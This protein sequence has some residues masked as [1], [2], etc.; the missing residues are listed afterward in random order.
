MVMAEVTIGAPSSRVGDRG[1]FL[2]APD[3]LSGNRHSGH[4][5]VGQLLGH[6]PPTRLVLPE[7]QPGEHSCEAGV[8]PSSC[9]PRSPPP[10][11]AVGRSAPDIAGAGTDS[12]MFHCTSMCQPRLL[13]AF[14]VPPWRRLAPA[15]VLARAPRPTQAMSLPGLPK[16]RKSPISVTSM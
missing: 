8:A 12:S 14:V 6:Q 9:A 13:P 2:V 10:D 1:V 15:R 3:C 5:P 4:H 16:R 7:D 11:P